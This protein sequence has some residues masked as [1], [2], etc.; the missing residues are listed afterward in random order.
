MRTQGQPH[1]HIGKFL[2]AAETTNFVVVDGPAQIP[3][4]KDGGGLWI[5][6]QGDKLHV[7]VGEELTETVLL[8]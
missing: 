8:R 3:V 4:P 1:V 6:P 5:H 7:H 2:T